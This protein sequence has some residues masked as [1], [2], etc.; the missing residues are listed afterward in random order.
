MLERTGPAS[1]ATRYVRM[2]VCLYVLV[3]TH[4]GL[5]YS[6]THAAGP[7]VRTHSGTYIS[8]YR[9]SM[10]SVGLYCMEGCLLFTCNGVCM[11]ACASGVGMQ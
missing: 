11:C 5:Q 10:H 8:T 7:S 2:S 6:C 3:R 9:G 1:F 4:P